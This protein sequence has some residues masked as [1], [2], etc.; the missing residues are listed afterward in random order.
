MA[1]NHVSFSVLKCVTA[2]FVRLK[3]KLQIENSSVVPKSGPII[4]CSNHLHMRDQLAVYY[5]TKRT[6][7]YMAKKEYF[8]RQ[9]TK[10]MYKLW[11][12]IPTDRENGKEAMDICQNLLEQGEAIGIFPEGTRNAL[13]PS[14]IELLYN[15]Y[16]HFS[17]MSFDS[18]KK[19][20]KESSPKVSQM[21]YLKTLCETGVIDKTTLEEYILTPDKLLSELLDNQT[22]TRY[23][24]NNSLL[25]PLKFG[26]VKLAQKTGA[27]IVT[28]AGDGKYDSGL[29][30]FAYGD[31]IQIPSNANDQEI[32]RYN[33]QIR[34]SII[35]TFNK[36]NQSSE[37]KG[38]T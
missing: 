10:T 29:V 2:P 12:A 36:I 9:P 1:N 26:A 32:S 11:G 4:I 21:N 14:E 30:R 7:H 37:Q 27:T 8:L 18:F 17:K 20:V 34:E 28:S 22:I 19:L 6:I 24:Y 15:E 3:F 35:K 33:E 31:L 23:D 25:L 13:K 38:Y 16:P 5:S